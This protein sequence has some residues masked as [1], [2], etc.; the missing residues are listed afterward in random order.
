MSS[1]GVDIVEEKMSFQRLLSLFHEAPSHFHR[2]HSPSEPLGHYEESY[3]VWNWNGDC[4]LSDPEMKKNP[5]MEFSTANLS[6]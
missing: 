2:A 3:W 1:S 5:G 4:F 6:E